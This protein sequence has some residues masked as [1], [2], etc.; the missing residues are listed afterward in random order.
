[1]NPQKVFEAMM[2]SKGHADFSKTKH[3]RYANT[4]LQTR[5]SYFLLGWEM[6]G[7]V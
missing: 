6:R 2:R 1:M 5:W 4:N 7:A 3:G